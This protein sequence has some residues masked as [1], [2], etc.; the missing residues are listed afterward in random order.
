MFTQP[1]ASPLCDVCQARPAEFVCTSPTDASGPAGHVRCASCVAATSAEFAPI[2][3]EDVR[4]RT[5]EDVAYALGRDVATAAASWTVDGTT[6]VEHVRRVLAML[7]AGDPEADVYLPAQ[8]NLSG[9]YADDPTPESLAAEILGADYATAA[10]HGGEDHIPAEQVDA[11]AD[12]FERGVEDVFQ[13]ECERLLRAA[14][15]S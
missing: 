11:L 14:L 3:H 7:D 15:E 9:E 10:D 8:P 2:G 12:A 4:P 5:P 1:P 6:P 13:P